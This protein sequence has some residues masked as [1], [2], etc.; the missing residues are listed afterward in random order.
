MAPAAV[1]F[2]ECAVT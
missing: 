1:A 2:I